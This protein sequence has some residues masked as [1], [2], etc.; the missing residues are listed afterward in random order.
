M[1]VLF[2]GGG[3]AGHINPAIAMAKYVRNRRPSA[4]ILFIGATGGMEEKLVREAG[5][6]LETF[7]MRGF[8]HSVS[9]KAC[10]YNASTLG[11][12]R[13]SIASARRIIEEFKPDV[14]LGTGG[15]ACFP[16]LYAGAK[17]GVPTA[18][19]ESNAL[20]G[21]SNRLLARYVDKVMIGFE[22]AARY[23]PKKKT[24]FTGN[25][26][27]EGMVYSKKAEAKK[28]LG[29]DRPLVYSFWGSLGAREMNRI[30]AQLFK[31]EADN[32]A[33]F[34]H[35]HSTGSFG[36]KWMPDYLGELGVNLDE[37]GKIDMREYVYNAPTVMAAADIVLCR[38]GA[39]TVSELAATGTPSIIIPS[40]NVSGHHQHKNARTLSDRGGAVFVEERDCTAQ[41]LY[42]T[43]NSLLADPERLEQMGR[44]AEKIAVYDAGEKIY[45]TLTEMMG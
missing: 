38:A 17:L 36:Y 24:E 25:P 7:P 21:R 26:L 14:I 20:P 27:R 33:G 19:H 11:K 16:P 43:I 10:V 13:A 5:F 45:R 42:D 9:P 39:M 4:G 22:D 15:F 30:T 29:I 34:S 23:F 3:T 32:D 44:N 37:Y 31:L 12:M 6:E 1:K 8:M 2:A 18:I 35:I 41:L 40:P 28:E